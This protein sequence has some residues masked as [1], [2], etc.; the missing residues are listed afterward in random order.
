MTQ[1]QKGK[2][3]RE[4]YR[5][6]GSK[7]PIDTEL[8][9]L[10]GCRVRKNPAYSDKVTNALWQLVGGQNENVELVQQK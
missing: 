3:L 2:R 8:N 9:K 1:E 5:I 4:L 6:A 7:G 10:I